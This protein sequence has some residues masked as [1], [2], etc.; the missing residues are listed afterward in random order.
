MGIP[1]SVLIVE[2][3]SDTV[4]QTIG[5][6]KSKGLR[7]LYRV[8][9]SPLEWEEAVYDED[10]DIILCT[11]E[12]PHKENLKVYLQF[13]KDKHI[14]IPIILLSKKETYLE[15]LGF[16]KEGVADVISR[17]TLDRLTEVMERERK[18]LVFRKEK[19]RTNIFL[20][21]SLKEIKF[22]KFAL[23]QANIVSITDANGI[24][25]YVN[26][27]FL[28]TTGFE[29]EDLI[30]QS[31]RILKSQDKTPEEWKKFWETIQKGKVWRGEITNTK[32]D[33]SPYYVETTV[34]PFAREDGSIFQYIAIHHDISDR[35]VAERQLT[36]DAFYDN[37]TGLPNRSLFLVKIELKIAEYN[38]NNI[39]FPIVFFINI[40][41]FKRINHSLG[42]E[43]GD[44]ILSIF[45][46]RLQEISGPDAIITRLSADNFAILKMD[47]LVV[48]EAIEYSD[49]ILEYLGNL[50]DYK[51]YQIYLTASCG[52]S[53]FGTGGRDSEL[54]LRNAEIAMF[55]A[56]EL[57]V[58]STCVFNSAMQERI[59]YQLGIQNDLKKALEAKEFFVCYQPIFHLE[60][61][62]IDH[63]EA[64]VRWKH[65]LKGMVSPVDFIPM[66]ESSGLILPLTK[67]VLEESVKLIEWIE[68]TN[69]IPISIAV[70]LS[71][72]VF[73][74]QNIFHW[75][76]DIHKNKN[77]RYAS[78]QVEITESLA[79]KNLSDT[80][81]ILSNLIDIGVKVALDDFG[82]GFS[83]L[84]YLEKLPLSTVKIDKSFLHNA[85]DNSKE[86]NLF[87]SIIKMAHVL[88][89]DVVAEGIEESTQKE[90]L[91]KFG[92]DQIQGYLISK[93]IPFGEVLPFLQNFKP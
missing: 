49:R 78:L 73:H 81:P 17:E 33:G 1:I 54:L 43:A 12:S 2:S 65:P 39:G 15:C 16:M 75:I 71:P 36:Y 52:I 5:E 90:L 82:T 80:Y 41:N 11:Y 18:S 92:C 67:F 14:D 89:Y 50:I 7:P 20:S 47:L 51:G 45:A 84:S 10:W 48:E 21:E 29:R 87:H 23:D 91:E 3:N 56:K 37:L 58:G 22:Q 70:N 76:V 69:Q 42:N 35:K 24:I 8:I 34:V 55:E 63:W 59:H 72:H 30:G 68:K 85:T 88:G 44:E 46:N 64:L 40:D 28:K 38:S 83:S 13:L 74:D 93:P 66:A 61:K 79:M 31:H 60:S 86:G 62:K 53:S 19:E 9:E 25:T 6:I 57:K 77:I 4:F 32:K 27:A 26:D